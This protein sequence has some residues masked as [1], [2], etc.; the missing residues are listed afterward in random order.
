VA[1][2]TGSG[3][4]KTTTAS[5][6]PG[7]LR[8]ARHRRHAQRHQVRPRAARC[9]TSG[10]ASACRPGGSSSRA[11]CAA[12]KPRFHRVQLRHAHPRHLQTSRNSREYDE[13]GA[14]CGWQLGLRLAEAASLTTPTAR[15]K[16]TSVIATATS[17]TGNTKTDWKAA[18]LK[19]TGETPDNTYVEICETE[20]T[21]PGTLGCQFHPEFKSKPMGAA[22][23]VQEL[24][25][26]GGKAPR[27]APSAIGGALVFQ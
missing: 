24:H 2:E 7:G 25:R 15:A 3:N 23:A 13:L 18:G 19:I 9:P 12:S 16:S 5:W 21:I 10:S 20:P 26:R 11:M 1:G 14:P 17:S 27:P 8:Q 22:S 6:L 4:W